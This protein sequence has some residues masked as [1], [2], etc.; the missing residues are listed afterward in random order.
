MI[1]AARKAVVARHL[2]GPWVE[3]L[4][5]GV[6]L[7]PDTNL[8][9]R[10]CPS[11]PGTLLVG[12]SGGQLGLVGGGVLGCLLA[13]AANP[14]GLGLAIGGLCLAVGLLGALVHKEGR[15][16]AAWV[17]PLLRFLASRRVAQ[18][19]RQ[20]SLQLPPPTLFRLGGSPGRPERLARLPAMLAQPAV[21]S[22]LEVR[23]LELSVGESPIGVLVDRRQR[24]MGAAVAVGGR[25]FYLLDPGTQAERLDAWRATLVALSRASGSLCRVQWV[26]RCAPEEA[27][28]RL[29][30]PEAGSSPLRAAALDYGQ[31]VARSAAEDLSRQ[32][33]LVLCV[34]LVGCS[35]A[36]VST[37]AER[38]GREL[39]LL[40]G[41]LRSAELSNVGPA[42][43]EQLAE[44]LEVGCVGYEEQWG[45]LRLG[46]QF[47][48]SYW[49]AEWPQV[50]V[51]PDFLAPVLLGRACRR[52]SLVMSPVPPELAHRQARSARTAD[53]AD[54]RLLS[55]A[56]FLP[57]ARTAK[58]CEGNLRREEELAEGQAELS[59]SAYVTVSAD[60]LEALAVQCAE[61]EQSASASR[62]ELRR[63][64]GLQAQAYCWTLPTGRGLG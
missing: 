57:S 56:G 16:L 24:R 22:G 36:K 15:F 37:A 64:W 54:E 5:K 48:A 60:D 23:R 43:F 26:L 55:Q 1:L 41:Q 14:A 10:M 32:V 52:V 11:S 49:V 34:P 17:F 3:V 12:L 45:Y 42:S 8:R 39:R 28:G 31:L 59:F 29:R 25:S 2:L 46:K 33:W 63:L 4:N 35:E 51:A 20:L 58:R 38:L 30:L 9:Y 13:A 7:M 44:L 61:L 40:D 6:F 27:S 53:V 18:R 47:H 19:H 21:A 62:L 50:E